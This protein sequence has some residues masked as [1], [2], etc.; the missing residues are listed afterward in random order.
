MVRKRFD[1]SKADLVEMVYFWAGTRLGIEV[2]LVPA[3]AD[4]VIRTSALFRPKWDERRSKE[5]K[6]VL[7]QYKATWDEES[8]PAEETNGTEQSA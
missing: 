4:H 3:I 6:G 2:E 1:W 5:C 8:Q 7:R